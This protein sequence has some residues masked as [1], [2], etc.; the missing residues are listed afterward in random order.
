MSTRRKNPP[1]TVDEV[2][3]IIQPRTPLGR[4]LLAIHARI[5]ASGVR[6]LDDDEIEQEVAERRGGYY[7]SDRDE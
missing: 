5:I 1:V 4:D 3:E 7:R 2:A 6:M